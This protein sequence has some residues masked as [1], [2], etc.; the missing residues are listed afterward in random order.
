[1]KKEIVTYLGKTY[2]CGIVADFEGADWIIYPKS[3]KAE[4]TKS[5]PY[6]ADERDKAIRKKFAEM[7]AYALD[8]GVLARNINRLDQYMATFMPYWF[9]ENWDISDMEVISLSSNN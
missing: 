7:A 1:M 6:D 3:L 9:S 4:L 2:E 5:L 8:D